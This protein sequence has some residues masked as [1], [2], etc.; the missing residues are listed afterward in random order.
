MVLWSSAMD[1]AAFDFIVNAH[2]ETRNAS[3]F[4]QPCFA[5]WIWVTMATT[6]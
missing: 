6:G 4:L 2:F 1:R 3:S 5:V